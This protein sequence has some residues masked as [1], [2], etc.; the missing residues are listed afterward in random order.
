MKE[1]SELLKRNDI[2]ANSYR[3]I[4]KVTIANTNI[5]KVVIKKNN[6]KDYIYNYLNSRNFNYYPEIIKKDDYIVSK[7]IEDTNIPNEQKILDLIDLVSLLHSK[8]THYKDNIEDE[9]KKIYE[10]LSNNYEY[11]YEYYND[12]INLIDNKVFFSPSESLLARNISFIFSSINIGKNY[13][14]EWFKDIDGKTQMRKTI[15]H[16]NLSLSHYIRSDKDYLISWDR[17]KIDIPIFD[18]YNLYN[19]HFKDFDFYEILKRY[20]SRYPLKKE[21]REL[22][23]I[24]ITM[25]NK[26]EYSGTEY[27]MCQKIS[28]EID[29]LYKSNA[30]IEQYKKSIVNN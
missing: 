24:L 10:D 1:V 23:F 9:Y 17:S 2:R 26:I 3:N 30:L 13:I 11:L 29:R 15:V 22:L 8:T 28:D 25:P 7:Y 12:L 18:L 27:E 19:N 20:E 6:D 16:N 21:E 5:G 14:D 4:G